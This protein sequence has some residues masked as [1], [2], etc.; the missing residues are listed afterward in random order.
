[1]ELFSP[2]T[3]LFHKRCRCLDLTRKEG[4]KKIEESGIAHVRKNTLQKETKSP[5]K[6][7]ETK[8]KQNILPPTHVSDVE[9]YT[10]TKIVFSETRSA[11]YVTKSDTKAHIDDLKIKPIV[12][13]FRF[14]G[15]F[16]L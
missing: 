14:S 3:S 5:T 6:T 2:K 1:M 4:E 13:I 16:M 8:K 10:G 11:S 12:Y 7:N 9:P 15:V